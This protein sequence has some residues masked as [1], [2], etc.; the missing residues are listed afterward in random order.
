MKAIQSFLLLYYGTF[1]VSSQ[2]IDN[3]KFLVESGFFAGEER[4]CAWVGRKSTQKRCEIPE[5]KINCPLTCKS[6]EE[7]TP[8]PSLSP[9]LTSAPTLSQQPTSS[10]TSQC[11]DNVKFLVESG[12]FAGQ[13]RTC[14]WVGRMLTQKRCEIPEASINCPLTCGECEVKSIPTPS[15]TSVPTLMPSP[16]PS[17]VPSLTPS[18]SNSPTIQYQWCMDSMERFEINSVPWVNRKRGCEW[19]KR[20]LWRCN[21]EEVLENCPITCSSCQCLNNKEYFEIDQTQ[22]TCDWVQE[23]NSTHLCDSIPS[24]KANCPLLCGE[25]EVNFPSDVPS[26]SPTAY[27][28]PS[29]TVVVESTFDLTSVEI[30]EDAEELEALKQTVI[31][32][33]QT[34]VPNNATVTSVTLSTVSRQVANTATFETEQTFSCSTDTCDDQESNT[35]DFVNSI[36]NI[37]Q[38]A[39]QVGELD[40]TIDELVG[41]ETD[42]EF[43]GGVTVTNTETITDATAKPSSI[44]SMAPTKMAS[45][46]PSSIPTNLPSITPSSNPSTQ[47]SPNP[48]KVP[49]KSPTKNPTK[50]PT[51][52]PTDTPSLEPSAVPSS[53]PSL[54]PSLAPSTVPSSMP[55]LTPSLEPSAVPSSIPSLI[56][57]A[58]PSSK[59]SLIPS[60]MP[61]LIPSAMPSSKPSLIPSLAPS[62]IPS[63]KPSGLPS[64]EPSVLPSSK[65]SSL[66]S[67][68]PSILPSSKPSSLPSSKPSS[69]PSSKPSSVPSSNPTVKPTCSAAGV[70]G[71]EVYLSIAT[72]CYRIQFYAGGT[73]DVDTDNTGCASTFISDGS[74]SSYV[75]Y[76][77]GVVTFTGTFTGTIT[78]KSDSNLSSVTVEVLVFDSTTEQFDINLVYTTCPQ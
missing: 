65:P 22:R 2:C 10:S 53:K 75:S 12:F 55:S 40:E 74:L 1:H 27:I 66:P 32:A 63:A 38:I 21:I 25:C 6:C 16:I 39:A 60:L 57:S 54:I 34:Y 62:S 46:K 52:S 13:E 77:G 17:G 44:P 72:S 42:F 7:I 78:I 59:P 24:V 20:N 33:F 11:V 28:Y 3:D 5:A 45:V 19:P 47:P 73:I 26:H 9:T 70:D 69:L 58:V 48:T 68:K 76:S 56:P 41:E 67:S 23:S 51:M 4:T 35:S 30:P 37:S 61:S 29:V 15:P 50:S 64:S 36:E 49:T 31:E 18:V 71:T 14:A 43:S 8:K